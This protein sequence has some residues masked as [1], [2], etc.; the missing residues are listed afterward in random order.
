MLPKALGA[1]QTLS[2]AGRPAFAPDMQGL[3]A[4]SH[5][6]PAASRTG[7]GRQCLPAA[8]GLGKEGLILDKLLAHQLVHAK[9]SRRR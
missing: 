2:V 5:D 9:L 6:D 3:T 8:P 7:H 1:S 4:S